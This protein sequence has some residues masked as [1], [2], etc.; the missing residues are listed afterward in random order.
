MGHRRKSNSDLLVR[1]P[2]VFLH[3]SADNLTHHGVF[4]HK[5]SGFAAESKADLSHLVRSDI[6]ALTLSSKDA[7]GVD[8]EER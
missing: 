4:P 6:V 5:Q 1:V 7:R 8:T 3:V 2:G